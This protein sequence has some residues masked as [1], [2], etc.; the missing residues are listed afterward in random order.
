MRRRSLMAEEEELN[1]GSEMKGAEG[2]KSKTESDGAGVG[3]RRRKGIDEVPSISCNERSGS[4][5]LGVVESSWLG[6]KSRKKC[7]IDD[8]GLSINAPIMTKSD[9]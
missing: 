5:R 3:S 7:Q 2:P 9:P 1:G 4:S 8:G 6:L